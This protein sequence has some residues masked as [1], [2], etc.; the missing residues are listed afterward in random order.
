MK[1]EWDTKFDFKDV[2]IRPKRSTLPSRS[3]VDIKREFVRFP[4]S[5]KTWKG[6]PIVA[7]NMDSTGT[8]AMAKAFYPHS[9]LTCLHKFYT[10]AQ[11]KE[12][13]NEP[14]FDNCMITTGVVSDAELAKLPV[15]NFL[16]CVAIELV[17]LSI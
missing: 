3:A 8:L 2:L 16:W 10:E 5:K 15:K 1:I 11:I 17:H 7:S 6:V 13:Y 9:M 14:F 12:V 4:H